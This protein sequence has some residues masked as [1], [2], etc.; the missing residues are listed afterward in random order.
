[1]KVWVKAPMLH[2]ADIL[3][4]GA[5]AE[6]VE[7]SVYD[8]MSKGKVVLSFCPEVEVPS[9]AL[10]KLSS[11]IRSSRPR[12]ITVLTVEG[13]PHCFTLHTALNE[14]LYV[15]ESTIPT[16]HY[17]IVG[18]KAVRISAESI[19]VARYLHLVNRLVKERP[20]V[21]ADLER[22]SLEYRL[23]R[24]VRRKS[25]SGRQRKGSME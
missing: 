14:A 15:T 16:R 19:R 7:R 22:Y 23:A 10:G 8:E 6:L 18:D 20:E 17:V 5:C 13:S 24:E 12:S 1:M 4:V 3:L 21:L 2:D 9:L 11:I 25:L